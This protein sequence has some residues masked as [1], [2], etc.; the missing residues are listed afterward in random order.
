MTKHIRISSLFRMDAIEYKP[1]GVVKTGFKQKFGTPR[2]SQIVPEAK[3]VIHLTPEVQPEMSLHCLSQFSHLWVLW[4]FSLNKN[5]R[6]HGKISPPRLGEK[7]GL[8]ASRSPHRPNPIGLSVVKIIKVSSPKIWIEGVDMVDGTPVLDIKPYM[9]AIE[10]ISDAKIGWLDQ[11]EIPKR[12]VEFTKKALNDLC[13]W[14][15]DGAPDNI[16]NIIDA[17]LKEDP[18]PRSYKMKHRMGEE[19]YF[20]YEDKDVFFKFNSNE[21]IIVTDIKPFK[22]GREEG[23]NSEKSS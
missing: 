9:P 6:F 17:S 19:L 8:F 1:I 10:A 4:H 2:Q 16:K 5:T 3:G 11:L 20:A 13:I 12:K 18:R 23:E 14:I 7:M 22:R 21:D 15:E